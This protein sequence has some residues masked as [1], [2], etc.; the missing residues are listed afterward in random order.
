MSKQKAL[1]WWRNDLRIDD[2]PGLNHAVE[3]SDSLFHVFFWKDEWDEPNPIGIPRMSVRRKAI[4][5]S[6]IEVLQAQLRNHNSEL[7]VLKGS[8]E[9]S[10]N[11]LFAEHHFDMIYA[12]EGILSEEKEEERCLGK[13]APIKLYDCNSL[14]HPQDIPFDIKD[15]PDVFSVF[16]KKVEKLSSIQA[17][18]NA[19]DHF[20]PSPI[21]ELN[22]FKF[23][24]ELKS[25][26]RSS[27]PFFGDEL[28]ALSRVKNYL[29]ETDAIASYKQTR[30]GLIGIQY[31]SKFSVFLALG[32]ISARRIYTEL[33]SYEN[34]KVKNSSTYWMYFELLW[35]DY[36][37]N[38]ARKY[39]DLLFCS[40][41][42]KY[43]SKKFLQNHKVFEKW[44]LGMTGDDFVDANMKELQ[45]TGFMSNRG[46]QNVASY[47]V[48]DLGIDWRW[49][50]WWFEHYLLDYDPHSNWGNWMYIAQVGND[51]REG[52]KFN[53]EH[54]ANQYDPELSY[55][56]LWLNE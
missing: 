45:A 43:P 54:Q 18:V 29:W 32:S 30:N 53:T 42:I 26:P 51:P 11:E 44:C 22:S 8:F 25:D 13:K 12:Q 10:V 36:F 6:A 56:N 1:Y 52:R 14:V 9:H 21:T 39:G 46:R 50:A 2:H 40:G 55:R 34:E 47:L 24:H 38:V 48:H 19:L 37:R 27:F 35:R 28:T 23:E 16:R 17:S 3:N 5:F 33:K 49:G 20:P 31:S 4:L 15:L 41:G 7:I